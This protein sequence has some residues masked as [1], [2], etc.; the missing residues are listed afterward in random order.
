MTFARAID[1]RVR[2]FLALDYDTKC[3]SLVLLHCR[4][5]YEGFFK[6]FCSFV[7]NVLGFED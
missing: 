5:Q 6:A 1:T 7:T 4:T 2:A 3:I